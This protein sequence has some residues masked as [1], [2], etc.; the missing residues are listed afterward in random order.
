MY[1]VGTV[2]AYY[3]KSFY[4]GM[5]CKRTGDGKWDPAGRENHS[6][7]Q[8]RCPEQCALGQLVGRGWAHP[9][10]SSQ[11]KK[12]HIGTHKVQSRVRFHGWTVRSMYNGNIRNPLSALFMMQKKSFSGV[13]QSSEWSEKRLIKRRQVLLCSIRNLTFYNVKYSTSCTILTTFILVLTVQM[14]QVDNDHFNKGL[15]E[16]IKRETCQYLWWCTPAGLLTAQLQL[17]VPSIGM[18]H[19][20]QSVL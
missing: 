10:F 3:C 18:L 20:D 11:Y 9:H 2:D 4:A 5:D 15:T 6:T 19:L 8:W 17:N 1:S 14:T 16:P 7:G 13:T 12:S